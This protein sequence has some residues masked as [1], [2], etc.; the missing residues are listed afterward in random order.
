MASFTP[1]KEKGHEF[2]FKVLP[3]MIF[4]MKTFKDRKI[5][6]PEDT[7]ERVRVHLN[8]KISTHGPSDSDD[9]YRID[10]G[11]NYSYRTRRKKLFG[12]LS[13][14]NCGRKRTFFNF[15]S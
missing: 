7:P 4:P 12:M 6:F 15:I 13:I 11:I 2:K 8:L 14:Q 9:K 1:A 5:N 10:D 3:I